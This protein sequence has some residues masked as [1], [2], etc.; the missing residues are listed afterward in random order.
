V[1]RFK[2]FDVNLHTVDPLFFGDKDFMVKTLSWSESNQFNDL[3]KKNKS[4]IYEWEISNPG[5]ISGGIVN[6]GVYVKLQPA[7]R[8]LLWDIDQE[9][10]TAK[11]SYWIDEDV[12]RMGYMSKALYAVFSYCK[13][14]EMISL[15]A[16]VQKKNVPSVGL[17]E[18][19]GMYPVGKTSCEMHGGRHVEHIIYRKDL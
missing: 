18:K 9:S 15:D 14:L 4:W 7:G 19:L 5:H 11:L 17:V 2:D 16:L 10:G 8:I 3:Q 13:S 12:A 1:K 6:I